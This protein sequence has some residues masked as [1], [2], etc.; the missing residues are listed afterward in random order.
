MPVQEPPSGLSLDT[1]KTK[2][3]SK[4]H[5]SNH[6]T[7]RKRHKF[8]IFGWL[9]NP[10]TRGRRQD[11]IERQHAMTEPVTPLEAMAL[12]HF[13]SENGVTDALDIAANLND[14]LHEYAHVNQNDPTRVNDLQG[15]MIKLYGELTAITYPRF[16]VNGRSLRSSEQASSELW[17]VSLCGITFFALAIILNAFPV[18]NSLTLTE[19]SWISELTLQN[20]MIVYGFVSE[21]LYPAVWGGLGASVFLTMKVAQEAQSSRFDSRRLRGQISRILLGTILGVVIANLFY[22]NIQ[23]MLGSAE[24]V[25]PTGIAFLAGIGVKPIYEA[26]VAGVDRLG[27]MIKAM[28]GKQGK[29]E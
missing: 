24:A 1:K 23:S 4:T 10:F 13:V 28:F 8:K 7:A 12:I 20:T 3:S 16:E 2:P 6:D 29:A 18:L 22:E 19:N 15:K 21:F 14:V 5:S 25:G 17:L 9:I 11:R 27:D 26:L